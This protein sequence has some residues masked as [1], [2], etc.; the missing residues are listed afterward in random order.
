ME[1]D[2]KF[3][4]DTAVGSALNFMLPSIKTWLD[5]TLREAIFMP[6][7]TPEHYFLPI[8]EGVADV[9]LP[10]GMLLLTIVE[11]RGVPRCVDVC[12]RA[13]P[14]RADA[15]APPHH[16]APSPPMQDGFAPDFSL[17]PGRSLRRGALRGDGFVAG[18]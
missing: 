15:R 13:P 12:L 4:A 6:Y 10:V 9:S 14:R 2:L 17:Q 18:V 1:Y 7:V 3:A 5:A 16:A 11:A 8:E